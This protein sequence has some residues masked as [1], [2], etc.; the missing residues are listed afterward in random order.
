MPGAALSAQNRRFPTK[1][2]PHAKTQSRKEGKTATGNL[3]S[4]KIW[5]RQRLLEDS[6]GKAIFQACPQF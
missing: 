6:K 1:P 2:I 4:Q 3:S 5:L